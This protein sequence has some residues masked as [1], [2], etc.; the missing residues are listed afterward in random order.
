MKW[1]AHKINEQKVLKICRKYQQIHY[2]LRRTTKSNVLAIVE[3]IFLVELNPHFKIYE[4]RTMIIAANVRTCPLKFYVFQFFR[5]LLPSIKCLRQTVSH[6]PTI[7]FRAQNSSKR[8][9][10]A[11]I[12]Y[13]S[14]KKS[15]T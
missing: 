11:S 15:T 8:M 1:A 10:C 9:Q 3:S 5:F 7:H 14:T 12:R 13:L 6:K 2:A 4:T